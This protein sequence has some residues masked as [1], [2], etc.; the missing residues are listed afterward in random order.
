MENLQST[1]KN[2][3][4]RGFHTYD[5]SGIDSNLTGVD[6]SDYTY[7]AFQVVSGDGDITADSVLDDVSNFSQ[8][9][10]A[11]NEGAVFVSGIVY[12]VAVTG[13]LVVR[14]FING[15]KA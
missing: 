6:G 5:S 13:D 3:G 12:N 10:P 9:V 15:K 8:T 11:D 1:L 7:Y 4:E 14:A 2:F